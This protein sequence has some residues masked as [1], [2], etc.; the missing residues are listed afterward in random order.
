MRAFAELISRDYRAE[1]I[2]DN[3]PVGMRMY[4][5]DPSDFRYER[6]MPL[7]YVVDDE[8]AEDPVDGD[9]ADGEPGKKKKKKKK[10]YSKSAKHYIFNHVRFRVLV[11][12]G[13]SRQRAG[14]G[15]G[16]GVMALLGHC[17]VLVVVAM[18]LS[19]SFLVAS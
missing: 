2:V 7:G 14:G 10:G 8:P 3:L 17:G 16:G 1:W 6:G 9:G 12:T 11:H 13:A 19:L 15:G 18:V 5:S 4:D